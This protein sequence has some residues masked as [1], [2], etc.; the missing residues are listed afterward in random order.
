MGDKNPKK[1]MK[2]KKIVENPVVETVIV[3]EAQMNKK[4][5]KQK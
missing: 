3:P 1:A 4:I 2:K 5:K